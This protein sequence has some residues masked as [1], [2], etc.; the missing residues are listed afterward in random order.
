MFVEPRPA[1]QRLA[2]PSADIVRLVRRRMARSSSV[3]MMITSGRVMRRLLCVAS[4]LEVLGDADEHL[5]RMLG[6][7]CGRPPWRS[8]LRGPGPGIDL[9]GQRDRGTHSGRVAERLERPRVGERS[10]HRRQPGERHNST[11]RPAPSASLS[12]PRRCGR[13]G[14][15]A[16]CRHPRSDQSSRHEW[17]TLGAQPLIAAKSAKTSQTASGDAGTDVDF[18]TRGHCVSLR[19]SQR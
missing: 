17:S 19:R 15:G 11:S 10:N 9:G 2:P 13:S 4:V 6:R 12:R 14:F 5:H 18:T 3:M 16:P 8:L 1:G 7:A